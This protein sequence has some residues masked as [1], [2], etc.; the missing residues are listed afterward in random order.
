MAAIEETEWGRTPSGAL[1]TLYTLSAG[2]GAVARL[3]SYGATLVELRAPDRRGVH[4][5]I[6]LGFDSLAPYLG[7]H[8]YF[9]VTVGRVANRIAGA[10]FSLDGETFNLFANDGPNHLHGGRLGFDKVVWEGQALGAN[11]DE[12]AVQFRYLSRD[13]EEGYPGNLDVTVRF[14]LRARGELQIDYAAT[15]DKATPVNLTN[16]TYWNLRGSGDILDHVLWIDADR[17][18]VTDDSLIPTGEIAPVE[19]TPFDFRS[20]APIGARIAQIARSPAGYDDNFALR[21]GGGPLS[22]RAR[23]T[24]PTSGRALE[25]RSTEPG[26]QVYSGNFLDGSLIGRGGAVYER[27]AGICLETQRFPGSVHHSHFPGVVLRPGE[28][29]SSSTVYSFAIPA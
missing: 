29:F 28:A 8:P 20:P 7:E 26:L 15:T 25:V 3:M 5:D 9:G 23:L 1:V 6:V 24:D 12:A 16:H 18:T 13:G 11:A 10:W 21:G 2:D 4:Q 14:T 27:Y 17:Y 22:L 19:G